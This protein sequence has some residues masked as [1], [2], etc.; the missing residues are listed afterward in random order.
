MEKYSCDIFIPN[1]AQKSKRRCKARIVKTIVTRISCRSD[2]NIQQTTRLAI[3]L[4]M[5]SIS[6]EM[7]I[8]HSWNK[9]D[10]SS[11]IFVKE[12]EITCCRRQAYISTDCIRGKV[13]FQ[14]GLHVWEIIWPLQHR[15]THAVIGVATSEAP[16]QCVE[17]QSIIG[18]ND[19]SWGWNLKTGLIFHDSICTTYPILPKSHEAFEIP[20]NILVLL[21]MEQ[22]TLSFVVN[23]HHLGVAF[24]GLK[25]KKLYPIVATVWGHSEVTM[26]YRGGL[27]PDPLPLQDLCR[28][29]IRGKINQVYLEEHIQQLQLPKSL[30]AYLS[31]KEL[32]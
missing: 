30:K 32:Y 24:R 6:H 21:N 11:N 17:Y 4:D 12:D 7:I 2:H 28:H 5:P 14:K 1:K 20:E 27:D 18:L 10:S 25:G 26:K 29:V 23:G 8:K 15:G 19:Q 9:E 31:N 3:L 13:G 16:L 22:G